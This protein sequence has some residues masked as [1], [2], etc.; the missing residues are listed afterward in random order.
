MM[1]RKIDNKNPRHEKVKIL[2]L[3]EAL[4]QESVPQSSGSWDEAD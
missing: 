2:V 1:I 3:K 4:M